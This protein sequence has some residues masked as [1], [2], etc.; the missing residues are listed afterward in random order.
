MNNPEQ[1]KIQFDWL[2]LNVWATVTYGYEGDPGLP[3]GTRKTVSIEEYTVYAGN[4]DF[5]DCL[6]RKALREIEEGILERA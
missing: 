2:T 5:M 1:R 6:S 4:V 3:F